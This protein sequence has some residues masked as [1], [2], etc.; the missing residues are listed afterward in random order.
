MYFD[1]LVRKISPK[2]KAITH[3]LNG[4]FTFF[5]DE[6]LFQ[7]ALMHLWVDFNRHKL[8]DKTDSYI[9]QGCYFHLKNHIRIVRDKSKLVSLDALMNEDGMILEDII[10]SSDTGEYFEYLNDK[11]LIE[12]MQ[13]NGLTSKEKEFLSLYLEGLTIREIGKRFGI[14]HV[15]V[16]KLKNKIRNKYE[17]FVRE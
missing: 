15:S 4:R 2:L 7:E 14:S 8:D 11:L 16:V 5:N 9:L 10:P 3:R 6:D 13:N 1:E 12:K 17:K